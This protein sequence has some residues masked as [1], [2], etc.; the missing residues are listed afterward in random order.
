M[1]ALVT[2]LV[3]TDDGSV[4]CDLTRP[5]RSSSPQMPK[6]LWGTRMASGGHICVGRCAFFIGFSYRKYMAI[7]FL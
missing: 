6:R 7:Y 3:T 5:S 2:A 4:S 1:M